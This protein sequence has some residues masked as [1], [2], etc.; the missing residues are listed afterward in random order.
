MLKPAVPCEELDEHGEQLLL[1]IKGQS[2]IGRRPRARL[3]ADNSTTQTWAQLL[4][5]PLKHN[6]LLINIVC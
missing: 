1:S 4:R 2:A 3:D 5:E 6:I